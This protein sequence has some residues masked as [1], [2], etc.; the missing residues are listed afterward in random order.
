VRIEFTAYDEKNELAAQV[1][2][3]LFAGK[4]YKVSTHGTG[5]CDGARA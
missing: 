2:A 4:P 5:P 1:D 3:T